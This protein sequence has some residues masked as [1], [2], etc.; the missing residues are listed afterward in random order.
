MSAD[1]SVQAELIA[2]ASAPPS[3]N[4]DFELL[5]DQVVC[6]SRHAAASR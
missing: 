2:V 5:L 1:G 4:G 6:V 3:D